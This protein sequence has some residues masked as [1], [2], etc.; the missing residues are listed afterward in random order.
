[1]NTR[2]TLAITLPAAVIVLVI[3]VLVGQ[4]LLERPEGHPESGPR[5]ATPVEAVPVRVGPIEYRRV[6]SGAL[7]ASARMT[8]APKV[9]GRVARLPVDLAD[10]VRR[11]DLVAQLDDDEARQ[12]LMQAEADLAV[13]VA[14]RVEAENAASI[15]EREFDRTQTLNARGIASESQLDTVRAESLSKN[16]ALEVARAQVTRAESARESARI[17]LG[18]TTIHAEWEGDDTERVVAERLAEEGDT[19]SANTPLLSMV[20]L[21][22]IDAVIFATER[23]Y[24]LLRPGQSVTVSADVFP[25]RVWEGTVARVAPVFNTGSRQARIE[26]T[27]PNPDQALKPGMFVRVEAVLDRFEGAISVPTAA[28]TER[29]GRRVIFLV[30][31]DSTTT[32]MTPVR[33]GVAQGDWSQVE[34]DGIEGLVITLG[35]QF[36]T[37]G[38]PIALPGP[39]AESGAAAR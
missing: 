11:G 16:A 22:P 4:R 18:Y 29:D 25:D 35:Q 17:R 24:A 20:D 6:F 38:A 7:E 31:P 9:S 13:A 26:L 1:M 15:A 32:R 37:D 39:A 3:A 27:L 5:A 30:D 21:D 2:T 12:A 23:D 8:V 14:G 19:V 36:L 10:R 33:V 34:G 28:L